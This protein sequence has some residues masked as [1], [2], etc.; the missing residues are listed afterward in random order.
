MSNTTAA[1][2]PV[3]PL[4]A[5]LRQVS[6]GRDPDG[7]ALAAYRLAVALG[8][9]ASANRPQSL[10]RALDLL[11]RAGVLFDA[12]R[13]PLEH[14]RVL[15]AT[16]ATWRA[17][18]DPRRAE[19]AFA[20]AA[21]LLAE[22]SR[23]RELGSVLSNLGLARLEAGDVAAALTS[24]D[25]ALVVLRRAGGDQPT[26]EDLRA[27]ASAALNRGQALLAMPEPDRSGSDDRITGDSFLAGAVLAI[28][29]GLAVTSSD[30]APLQFGMLHHTLGLIHM[31]ADD[32]P[33]AVQ[34]FT[35][36]LTVFTRSAFPFQ[37]AIASFNRGRAFERSDDLLRALVD[38]EN[39][40]QL[41]D[42]RMHRDQWLEAAT[43][44]A[45]VERRLVAGSPGT[46]R[47]DHVVGL[48]VSVGAPERTSLL[49]ERVVRLLARAPE[50]RRGELRQLAEAGQRLGRVP[51]DTLLRATIEVFMEL[52]D[53]VLQSGLLAQLDAHTI[54]P[55]EE[56][57]DADRR[58]DTAIQE[59]VMGPQRVRMR[60]V[61]YEAGWERP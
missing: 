16:G 11:G 40:A 43:R 5:R 58:F 4:D 28:D 32:L 44:L 54:L 12:A 38:Y 57:A 24:F 29:E 33:S 30:D 2:G 18:G 34:S 42:P 39:A 37:H 59:L 10:R 49:R 17:M 13:A 52:P 41:F 19:T 23:D 56:R 15:N 48:L 46:V 47:A 55:P 7:W 27:L 51:C 14:A 61:L 22:R 26:S 20:T 25:H 3:G 8:E 9:D 60:D 45:D 31:R 6:P 53:E 36:A 1:D 35:A 21:A 50:V